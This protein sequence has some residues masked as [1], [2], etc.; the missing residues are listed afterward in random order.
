[1]TASDPG[2]RPHFPLCDWGAAPLTQSSKL[3]WDKTQ[4]SS[5]LP[6]K[7]ADASLAGCKS[8]KHLIF[9]PARRPQPGVMSHSALRQRAPSSKTPEFFSGATT[10]WTKDSASSFLGDQGAAPRRSHAALS[11]A[12]TPGPSLIAHP[13]GHNGFC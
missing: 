12:Q 5:H 4:G 10:V 8:E 11:G 9:F 1:M 3:S 13:Q 7:R 6:L 2:P